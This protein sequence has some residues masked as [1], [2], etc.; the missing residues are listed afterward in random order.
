VAKAAFGQSYGSDS[1]SFEAK[2]MAQEQK[3]VLAKL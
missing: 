2:A 3:I 1:N